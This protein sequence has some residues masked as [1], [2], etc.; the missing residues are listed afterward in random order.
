MESK[1]FRR[2][3]SQLTFG[4]INDDAH[5]RHPFKQEAKMQVFLQGLTGYENIIDTGKDEE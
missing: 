3:H 2:L 1:E 4:N 5:C